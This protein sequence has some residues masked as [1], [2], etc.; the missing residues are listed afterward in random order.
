MK[1]GEQLASHLTPE[2]RKQY[3]DYERLKNLLYDNMMEVPADDDRREEHISRIDEQFFNECDQELTKINLFFS[4]KIAEAQGKFYELQ[5]ELQTY[6]EM[7]ESRKEPASRRRFGGKDKMHKEATRNEQQLKLA[8]SEFYLGLVLVQNYQQLNGTGFRK[9]LKKHDKLANNERGLDWRINKVEKSSFFLN[10]EI[11]TL[12]NNVETSVINELEAGNRQ[13]GMK[14]LKVPPLSEK[15]RPVT[16]FTLG[17]FLG[18]SAILLVTIALTWWGM[19]P[20][21][22]E[23]K[24]VAVR[25]F[26]GPLLIF[27]S[28]FLCGVNMAGWASAGV[29]HVLIFEV[30]PRNHLSYQTLM[31]IAS[32]MIMVWSIAVLVYQYAHLL[33][34]PP[35]AAPLGL[36]I[37]C[38]LVLFNP[39]KSPNYIFHR[40]SR[41]WLIRHFVKCASAPFH[42]VTFTDFWLG[43]QM[44]SLTTAFLDLQYFLCFYSMEVDYSNYG[45]DVRAVNSTSGAIPWGFVDINTGK[46][47][48]T[49]EPWMRGFVSIIPAFIRLMQCFRRYRDTGR[50]HPHLV[51][52]G[53]YSTTILVVICGALNKKFEKDDPNMTSF[54]F[55]VWIA[56]YIFSFTYTF[57]WDVF[58][59]WGLIDPRAPKEAPFLREEMI[60]GSKFY[61]YAA[62]LQDFVLRLSWVLNVSLGEAWTLDSDFLTTVTA[63]FEVFR[64]F[65][66]NYF[67]LENE[68]VNNCGQFRA[69][70]D[71]SIKPIRKGDLESLLSKIDQIDGVTHRGHD[72]MERVKKQKKAAKSTRQLLR[73]TRFNRL[74]STAPIATTLVIQCA[75]EGYASTGVELNSVL[76]LYSKYRSLQIGV[77]SRAKF[78]RK[79]IFKTDLNPYATAVIFGAES[80][81]GDLVP[82]LS[83]MR[84]GTHLLACRF[85]LPE[86]NFWHLKDQIGEGIDAVWM[87]LRTALP[88][89]QAFRS[90]AT[91]FQ[92]NKR[93]PP[94]FIRR[95]FLRYPHAHLYIV[96][97]LC[98]SAMISP[99]LHSCYMYMTMTKFEF[100]QYKLDRS[101]LVR[102]RQK[103]G[104]SLWIPFWSN[105]EAPQPSTQTE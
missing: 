53:K 59:D 96:F 55:Y 69:V 78:V 105:S 33:H 76:V 5:T 39:I 46:D 20:R 94:A 72:L 23:P 84:V 7:L 93:F 85:P 1:F 86:S 42:F 91:Y 103:F 82:K 35:F 2:W 12:I 60:Y 47:M 17:L 27:L 67:R 6:K 51:N 63:P 9:I 36:M 66:W 83:E 38:C 102:E 99:V 79:D 77:Q 40:D 98:S 70:R 18:A 92:K 26:R 89:V 104:K 13:A 4:Q 50:V 45:L 25:L 75:Q 62:I 97:G 73:K 28:I 54:V 14:R 48:C 88:A 71:I 34:I 16:T 81:M 29:N 19:P 101:A 80:L 24:W 95:F 31:Q 15:Q 3:I 68:H 61:Y 30:D 11:E 32:F 87:I 49:S 57:L 37:F 43:D 22:N 21:Q 56:S 10:R 90:R 52:A 65:I 64:R 74:I 41:F 8:F 100:E 44:N 58:M